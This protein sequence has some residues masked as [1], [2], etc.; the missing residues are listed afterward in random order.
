MLGCPLET[1]TRG[2]ESVMS[3]QT[4]VE[5]IASFS[6]VVAAL[7]TGY[8][9]WRNTSRLNEQSRESSDFQ[10]A[11]GR[12]L[13]RLR[14]K[15]DHGRLVYGA[16]W[17]AE[18]G[19]YQAL[20]AAFV[21]VRGIAHK[22]TNRDEDIVKLGITKRDRSPQAMIASLGAVLE[23]YSK[24]MSDCMVAINANAP[25]YDGAIRALANKTHEL[26]YRIFEIH[27]ALFVQLEKQLASG[28]WKNPVTPSEAE[29]AWK[30][31]AAGVDEIESAI[32]KRMEEVRV[33]R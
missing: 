27:G 15:L 5:Q 21:P 14:A 2:R 19:A 3:S 24:E 25:F 7:I 26:A 30:T 28:T 22:L 8:F 16:Q 11:V 20:W 12:E 23:R 9:T 18:F 10:G 4:I 29:Q 32:R 17:N 13:E 1:G 6:G 33:L 31:F